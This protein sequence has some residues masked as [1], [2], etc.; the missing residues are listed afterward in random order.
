MCV[1]LVKKFVIC[2][3]GVAG[4]NIRDIII[5]PPYK[6]MSGDIAV[7]LLVKGLGLQQMG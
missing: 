3:V 7:K 4:R 1:K 6:V 5:Y 2:E